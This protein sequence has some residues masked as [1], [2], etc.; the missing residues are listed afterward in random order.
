MWTGAVVGAL[1]GNVAGNAYAKTQVPDYVPKPG[2]TPDVIFDNT[3]GPMTVASRRATYSW[4][5]GL[6]GAMLGVLLLPRMIR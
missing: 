3:Q 5:F 1:V 6:A 2:N 4:G